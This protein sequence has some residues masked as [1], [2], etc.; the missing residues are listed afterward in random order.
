[1]PAPPEF[2]PQRDALGIDG[3][4]AAVFV[5]Q[6]DRASRVRQV[7]QEFQVQSSDD[8]IRRGCELVAV[9]S[10]PMSGFA[11]SYPAVRFVEGLQDL[12]ELR[13]ALGLS[14]SLAPVTYGPFCFL[15]DPDGSVR[16]ATDA[17]RASAVWGELTRAL[18]EV[19]FAPGEA[20]GEQPALSFAEDEA[21][22]QAAWLENAEWAKV[23][24][25]NEE[26]RQPSRWWLDG[27]LDSPKDGSKYLS[28]SQQPLLP[29]W[30]EEAL[31]DDPV[32]A[33]IARDAPAWYVQKM[34]ALEASASEYD[35]PTSFF[36]L[37]ARGVPDAIANVPALPPDP[38]EA[39]AR[40]RLERMESALAALQA[41][42]TAA[43]LLE[44]LRQQVADLK[45]E[46]Q[47]R[48]A[49]RQQAA[50]VEAVAPL[51]PTVSD[52]D[53]AM[54]L[55]RAGM[56][57][58]GLRRSGTSTR[59]RQR[60][61]L[62]RELEATVAELEADGYRNEQVLR[63]LKEQ[64]AAAYASAPADVRAAAEAAA[65]RSG[66]DDDDD[67]DEAPL[68]AREVLAT[69]GERAIENLGAAA[70]RI[71][72]DLTKWRLGFKDKRP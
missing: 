6:E 41:D 37:W 69:F 24:E 58:L 22:R 21:M 50:A 1:M 63:P 30:T 12:T 31:K 39:A 11:T 71:D 44:P 49:Q 9:R 47:Q 25:Q 57:A 65:A 67:D 17:V 36:E 72:I 54:T 56:L 51:A 20:D 3:Q 61:R 23:L 4:R 59:S 43:A 14:E 52:A 26:L 19:T 10:I 32:K 34:M 16:V 66:A 55:E 38:A 60:L 45:A 5:Y 35:E 46:Q 28:A 27:I 70:E 62:L 2:F 48:L 53:V 64:V 68:T 7:L 29:S 18:H 8:Y 42:G 33:R 40:E 13:A 15:I